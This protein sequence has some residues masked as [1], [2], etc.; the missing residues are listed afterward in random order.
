MDY[1]FVLPPPFRLSSSCITTR[2]PLRDIIIIPGTMN[3]SPD[4]ACRRDF[5]MKCTPINLEAGKTVYYFRLTSGSANCYIDH[6]GGCSPAMTCVTGCRRRQRSAVILRAVVSLRQHMQRLPTTDPRQVIS[7]NIQS[8]FK[9]H[10]R[11]YGYKRFPIMF[12]GRD[13]GNNRNDEYGPY[14][15]EGAAPPRLLRPF[16][17]VTNSTLVIVMLSDEL[18][19]HRVEPVAAQDVVRCESRDGAYRIERIAVDLIDLNGTRGPA[20]TR[21]L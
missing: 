3:E 8:V 17:R 6:V 15:D 16:P 19:E 18:S 14:Q 1:Y 4:I 11:V 20:C 10:H 13:S 9:E 5:I 21:P 2:R 7:S 12:N